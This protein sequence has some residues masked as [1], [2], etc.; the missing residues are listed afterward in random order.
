M[1][2][3]TPEWIL[4]LLFLNTKGLTVRFPSPTS[5]R[6]TVLSEIRCSQCS[7]ASFRNCQGFRA[8]AS[9]SRLLCLVNPDSYLLSWLRIRWQGIDWPTMCILQLLIHGRLYLCV[10]VR[11]DNKVVE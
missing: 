9:A 10:L 2:S 8:F 1:Y 6:Y 3:S 7:T 11:L 5:T 4:R